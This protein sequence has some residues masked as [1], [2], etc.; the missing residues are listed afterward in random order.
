MKLIESAYHWS[1]STGGEGDRL[2]GDQFA[3]I[4]DEI[5]VGSDIIKYSTLTVFVI[6]LIKNKEFWYFTIAFLRTREGLLAQLKYHWF[7]SVNT[8]GT[9]ILNNSP[10]LKQVDENGDYLV[11]FISRFMAW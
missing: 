7:D 4:N 8:I 2:G 5:I 10:D 6:F 1:L 9:M 11:E 3:V